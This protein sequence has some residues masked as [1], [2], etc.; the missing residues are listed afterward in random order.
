MPTVGVS[1]SFVR[2]GARQF[3]GTN[4]VYVSTPDSRTTPLPVTFTQRHPTVD[5]LT[6]TVDTIPAG[7]NYSYFS[8]SGL[9]PGVDTVTLSAPGYTSSTMTVVVTTPQ[10]VSSNL[11]GSTTTTNPP[12][13]LNVYAADSVTSSHYTLSNLTVHAVS[14]DTTVVKPALA[15]FQIT[16][17]NYYVSTSVNIIGPGSASITYSDSA[18]TGYRPWTT[19]TITVTG[20]SLSISNGNTML[21]MRQTGGPT[22]AYVSTPNNVAT[23]LTVNLVSTSTRVVSVPASVT[24]PAGS[25]YAYFQINALDT[26]GT[27][28]VQATATGYNAASTNVQVTAPKLGVSVNTS[29]RTTQG[30]QSITVYAEDQAGNAHYTTDSVRVYLL[31]TAPSV[32]SVDSA[33]VLI[34]IG[35]YYNSNAAWSPASVG[36]TQLQ[37]TDSRAVF[38]QYAPTSANL[39]VYEPT[40]SFSW[41]STPLGIGQ[42]I[43]N[44]YVSTPDPVTS[45]AAVNLTH[46]AS[47]FTSVQVSGSPVTSVTIPASSNYVYFRLV[48]VAAGTDSLTASL[49]SP[50]HLPASAITVVGNGRVDT[51]GNW[52]SSISIGGGD[53]VLVTLYAFDPSRTQ[54]NVL[55]ATTFNLT[56]SAP[57]S[58]VKGG[59]TITSIVM[60]AGASSVQFYVKGISSGT[61]NVS[62]SA[63]NYTTWNTTVSISP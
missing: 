13:G 39:S 50:A 55:A 26:L 33:S 48:G 5:S 22:S 53:S 51:P 7:T 37:L 17:G 30:R 31:S 32:G 45:S 24:I 14:S 35:S 28:Q 34:P 25:N 6:T 21:G 20:P 52:P 11:P 4:G 43:D 57:M 12:I 23:P 44:E 9:T 60:P 58:F 42:Y 56:S 46:G 2:L 63:T 29:A 40:L 18:G 54:R 61:A 59:S 10:L 41:S 62:I 15:Y 19:N 8:L 3:Y 16:A 38:Y 47:T 27:I 49:G 1:S 36:S